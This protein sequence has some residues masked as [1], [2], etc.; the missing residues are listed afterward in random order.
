[1]IAM[2]GIMYIFEFI[3]GVCEREE[4]ILGVYIRVDHRV[5]GGFGCRN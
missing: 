3:A 5:G 1:M 2:W 4:C